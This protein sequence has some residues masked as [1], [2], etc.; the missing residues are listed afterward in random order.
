[1]KLLLIS[2]LSLIIGSGEWL[3]NFEEAKEAATKEH[4]Y[5]LLNFAGTDW[6]APC[7]KMKAEVFESESFLALA[8]KQLVL[9][10]ADFPRLK[11]NQLA[12]EQIKHNEVLAEKYNPA[13]KFPLTVLLDAN[14]HI[15]REWDGYQFGSQDD[16]MVE[17]NKTI[18]TK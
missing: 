17:L 11:K 1:M 3:T 2:L 12:K 5:I 15:L 7:I 9:V 18:S 10:R 6:C 13:G 16:F 4:K 14:G 8:E